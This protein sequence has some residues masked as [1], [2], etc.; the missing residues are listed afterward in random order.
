MA[1]PSQ[2]SARYSCG[3]DDAA[4]LSTSITAAT[5][6]DTCQSWL[7]HTVLERSKLWDR[8]QLRSRYGYL[9]R[10]G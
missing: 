4:V 2:P 10:A 8:N 6:K 5:I 3:G 1:A 9:Q 7:R